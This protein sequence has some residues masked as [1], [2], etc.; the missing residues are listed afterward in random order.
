MRRIALILLPLLIGLLACRRAETTGPKPLP[1]LPVTSASSSAPDWI[2]NPPP[3]SASGVEGPDPMG[4]L[5]FQRTVATAKA[6]TRLA[7]DL[8]NQIQ[9]LYHDLAQ[10]SQTLA[11]K[12][13]SP[14]GQAVREGLSRHLVDVTLRGTQARRFYTDPRTGMLWVLVVAD[15]AAAQATARESLRQRLAELD[16]GQEA[17]QEAEGRMDELFERRKAPR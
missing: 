9:G 8:E 4:D 7:R 10:R 15:P 1:V 2:D 17:L 14:S 16:L 5:D 13:Q 3:G 11:E 6:R 12:M